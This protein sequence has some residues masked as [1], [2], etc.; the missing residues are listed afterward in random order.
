MAPEM[1]KGN[2]YDEKVDLFSFGIILCEIIGRVEADPDFMPRSMDFGLN[3][4]VFQSKYC[5]ECPEPFYK[6]AFLCCSI[7]PDTRPA[8][9]V[10]EVWLESLALHF[11]VGVP[12]PGNLLV[13]I[14]NF[15][16]RSPS[17][18][19]AS[20]PDEL[21]P[22]IRH[23][24][25][26]LRTISEGIYH[27]NDSQSCSSSTSFA[28]SDECSDSLEATVKGTRWDT[29]ESVDTVSSDSLPCYKS[30]KDIVLESSSVINSSLE[31]KV[32]LDQES[33]PC[34]H[35]TFYKTPENSSVELMECTQL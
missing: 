27:T 33:V 34:V 18:S 28:F 4:E 25:P 1:M 19:E 5:Q 32:D 24:P 14:Y 7:N 2:K 16:T 26:L 29:R 13:D 17:T 9:E 6:I 20:T 30:K 11:T 8:F 21:S 23:P 22:E 10:M 31:A 3:E 35:S 15:N 12:L